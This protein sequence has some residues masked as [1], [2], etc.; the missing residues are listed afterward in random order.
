MSEVNPL[1]FGRVQAEVESLRRD[2]EALSRAQTAAINELTDKISE[3]VML[4]ERGKGAFWL[5]LS[6]GGIA[7][8]IISPLIV[9]LLGRFM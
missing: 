7:G 1:E 4:A 9:K 3:L 6:I 8:S 2:L 5:A